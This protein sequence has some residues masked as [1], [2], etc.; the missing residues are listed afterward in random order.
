MQYLFQ[1]LHTPPWVLVEGIDIALP[2]QP[3]MNA[4]NGVYCGEAI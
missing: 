2:L 3:W 1:W 4:A